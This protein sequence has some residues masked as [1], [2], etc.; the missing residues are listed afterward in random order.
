[1]KPDI[2]VSG[3]MTACWLMASH[4]RAVIEVTGQLPPHT[5]IMLRLEMEDGEEKSPEVYAKV[6]HS[7][8]ESG[9]RYLIHFT[10]VT[11]GLQAQLHRL[12][13]G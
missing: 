11:P 5:N 9:K 7:V 13:T 6:I 8:D 1:M 3:F 10:S 2:L 12:V 4:R